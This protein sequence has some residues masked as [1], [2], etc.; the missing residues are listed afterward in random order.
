MMNNMSL[1]KIDVEPE[2]MSVG[3]EVNF[4][5]DYHSFYLIIPIEDNSIWFQQN[6][7]EAMQESK[8]RIS[9][10]QKEFPINKTRNKILFEKFHNMMVSGVIHSFSRIDGKPIVKFDTD[11][12]SKQRDE[13]INKIL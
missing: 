9:S 5:F 2:S 13:K 1:I 7:V 6:N 8:N 11:Y 10:F 3:D 12:I 4:K